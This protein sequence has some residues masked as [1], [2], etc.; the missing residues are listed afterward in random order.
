MSSY[1][2]LKFISNLR[3]DYLNLNKRM[4]TCLI[5]DDYIVVTLKNQN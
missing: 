2:D 4:I 1:I 3:V 5:L